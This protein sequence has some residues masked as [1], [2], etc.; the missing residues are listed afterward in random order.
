MCLC[1]IGHISSYVFVPKTH[2]LGNWCRSTKF[3]GYEVSGWGSPDVHRTWTSTGL[4]R[5]WNCKPSDQNYPLAGEKYLSTFVECQLANAALWNLY[6]V[7]SSVSSR[8]K[9]LALARR[10]CLLFRT[11]DA[12]NHT[13]HTIPVTEWT[14]SEI[15]AVCLSQPSGVAWHYGRRWGRVSRR[16]RTRE[17]S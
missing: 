13:F 11:L 10:R 17:T 6:M 15:S 2:V 9:R 5:N 14:F 4:A 16:I 8:Q 1:W 12:A 3:I 7:P